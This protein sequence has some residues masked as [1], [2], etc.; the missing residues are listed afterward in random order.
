MR[1]LEE[2]VEEKLKSFHFHVQYTFLNVL[3]EIW[4]RISHGVMGLKY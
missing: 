1:C 4:N 3:R 2:E